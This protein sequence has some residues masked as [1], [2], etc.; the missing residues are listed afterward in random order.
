M[1]RIPVV[2]ARA[3]SCRAAIAILFLAAAPSVMGAEVS[4]AG[5][6]QC[7]ASPK[8]N[9]PGFSVPASAVVDGE[10]VTVSRVVY[11][12]GSYTD[13]A[14]E[15]TGKGAVRDGRVIVEMATA[16]ANLS[17]KFEGKVSSTEM[18][19]AGTEMLKIPDRGEDQRAC[20][21]LLTRK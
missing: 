20:K 7:D 21:A 14:G 16:S 3:K 5:T 2:S 9:I 11:K 18:T 4:Y 1:R 12:P 13:V 19:L 10:R 6:W 8:A 15:M 17:G